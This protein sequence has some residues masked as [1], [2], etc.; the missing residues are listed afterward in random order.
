MGTW[1]RK[2]THKHPLNVSRE[3]SPHPHTH[4][5]SAPQ[6]V[7]DVCPKLKARPHHEIGQ[8]TRSEQAG[9]DMAES[10]S[11]HF[12]M[13]ECCW[14]YNLCLDERQISSIII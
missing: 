3:G 10:I 5:C 6:E 13:D 7:K 4:S 9:V 2:E 11:L 14:A 8:L 1:L 12:H